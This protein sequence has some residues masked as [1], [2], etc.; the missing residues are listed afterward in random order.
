MTVNP[1]QTPS[2]SAAPRLEP[3]PTHDLGDLIAEY[4]VSSVVKWASY[5]LVAVT[6]GLCLYGLLS[7]LFSSGYDAAGQ[8]LVVIAILLLLVPV[9]GFS[10]VAS[11]HTRFA[12][13][14]HGI[15][16][17]NVVRT[18]IFRYA[19][20]A[21]MHISTNP[22]SN[23]GKALSPLKPHLVITMVSPLARQYYLCPF[24]ISDFQLFKTAI[25]AWSAT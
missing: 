16:H 8:R 18:T 11:A 6:G 10:A 2:H 21:D 1:Y 12:I 20:I 15:L 19:E 9:A 24:L 23:V 5:V 25:N 17:T 14:R 22:L 3:P 4:R 13:Y 7:E